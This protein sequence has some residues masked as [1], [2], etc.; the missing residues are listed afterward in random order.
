MSRSGCP[1]LAV[2][3]WL[4]CSGSLALD[5]LSWLSCLAILSLLYIQLDARAQ[6]IRN[7]EVLYERKKQEA[8]E[9]RQRKNK[10]AKFKAQKIARKRKHGGLSPEIA[11]TKN[12][13]PAV[14]KGKDKTEIRELTVGKKERK[15]E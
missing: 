9:T 3:F 15:R 13:R 1:V 5:V 4:S 12:A 10:S 8:Q 11:N 14:D 7:A 2:L 6:I